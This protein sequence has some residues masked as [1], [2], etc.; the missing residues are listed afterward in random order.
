LHPPDSKGAPSVVLRA[1]GLSRSFGPTIALSDVSLTVGSGELLA[2]LGPN[3][4]GKTTLLNV[5]TGSVRPTHGTV[6]IDGQ[7][8]EAKDPGWR[9]AIGVVSHRSGVYGHLSAFEN[10]RFFAVLQGVSGDDERCRLALATVG[11]EEHANRPV[12]GFSRGMAQRLAIAR[13]TLHDPKV[14][15]FDEPF[16]GLDVQSSERLMRRL[17]DL[18]KDGRAIVL[19]THKTPVAA[20]LA[21]RVLALSQGRV[22][23]RGEDFPRDDTLDR[24]LGVRTQVPAQ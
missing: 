21:D 10:L 12:R 1:D 17:E 22:V 20:T 8:L 4:A 23:Y 15:L 6:A 13:A 2:V 5:L 14:L 19:V 16:T 18:K 9:S 3:G 11:L 24:F 7:I